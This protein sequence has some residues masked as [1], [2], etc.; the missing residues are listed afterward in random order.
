M[1]SSGRDKEEGRERKTE[2]EGRVRTENK[3][4]SQ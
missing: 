3:G 4:K 1:E 2:K